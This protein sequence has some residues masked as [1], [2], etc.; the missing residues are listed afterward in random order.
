MSFNIVKN[1][2]TKAEQTA[3]HLGQAA[4]A[5]LKFDG[6]AGNIDIAS[7]PDLGTKFSFELIIQSD[8]FGS[9]SQHFIDFGT[10]GRFILASRSDVDG[11]N[12]AINDN[13]AWT[14]F[15]VKV[16]DDLKVHHLTLTVDGTAAI[17]YNNGNQVATVTISASHGIDNCTNARIG[18]NEDG[19]GQF[20]DGTIYRARF[21]NKT[22]SQ[23]EVTASYENATVPFA[24]Q[25]GVQTELIPS[26]GN[27]TFASGIGNWSA[28]AI[29]PTN[30]G[31]MLKLD[32]ALAYSIA[33]NLDAFGNRSYISDSYFTSLVEGK[34]YRL[35]LDAKAETAGSKLYSTF[36]AGGTTTESITLTDSTA[37]YEF[38]FT[39]GSGLSGTQYLLFGLDAAEAFWIDNLTLTRVGAVAD[40]DL[41]F[42]NPTQSLLVQDRAGAADGTSSATGV[43]QVTPIVQVNATAARIGTSAATP[44]DGEL[45]VSGKVEV[46]GATPILR[47]ND[48]DSNAPFEARVEGTSFII[49]DVNNDRDL[50]TATTGHAITIGN[51][52]GGNITLNTSANTLIPT[53]NVG[54]GG[55]PSV[56]ANKTTLTTNHATWGG[57]Y[58]VA[59]NGTVKSAWD[60]GTSGTTN[61]GSVVAEPLVLLTNSAARVTIDG[62]TGLATFAG[63]ALISTASSPKLDVTSTGA[64]VTNTVQADDASGYLGTSTNHPLSLRTNNA[65]RVTIPATGGIYEVG[66]VLKSNLLT[67]SGFD[68][69]SNSTL[70]DVTGSNLIVS[71]DDPDYPYNTFTP[72]GV[73]IDSAITTD[74]SNNYCKAAAITGVTGKLYKL[75]ATLT[76]NS[77]SNPSINVSA[78]FGGGTS[79]LAATTLNAG[80][81]TLVFE[82]A[83][84]TLIVWINNI[85]NTNWDCDFTLTEVT[86]GCVSGT[87]NFDGWQR[88]GGTDTPCWRQHEDATFTKDGSFY[89]LKTTSVQSAWNHA[90]PS[91]SL[92]TDAKFLSRFAGRTVT[93]GCW[94]YSTLATPEIRLNIYTNS[95]DN[96]STQTVA[97][98]TWTW[99]ETT[100]TCPDALTNFQL[101]LNK[102]GS[103][104]ETYYVSQVCLVFGSAIGE[105]NYTRPSG[106]IVWFEKRVNSNLLPATGWSDVAATALNLEADSNGVIP[107]GANAIQFR[108]LA[109]DSGSA[110]ATNDGILTLG[111]DTSTPE[112]N[113]RTN[114][115]TN[116]AQVFQ[117]GWQSCGSDGD[118]AYTIAATGSAT[119]DVGTFQY[120][121][122]QLR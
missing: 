73:N 79:S 34:K 89:S 100:A 72:N 120:L 29:T 85:G 27:R 69:W 38:V 110:A 53:G 82:A 39:A 83:T 7:P 76:L 24:D 77:G 21:W 68:V 56:V 93:A 20:I 61:F 98:N 8:S 112:Q 33:A 49:N 99:L 67:N 3:Q 84:D 86:P 22:L 23:A 66:G 74:G 41:A 31:G 12:L 71:W 95:G 32:Q 57:R 75:T 115:L 10:G 107:K 118:I 91:Q 81:N 47:L 109:N 106:E 88:R 65:A 46:S 45:A 103:T 111:R 102:S 50:F 13:T 6:A 58:E 78:A 36:Q 26:A 2:Y 64:T 40:Y 52:A 105:G 19:L 48:T 16:L 15:G 25:Y 70:E 96:F 55:T 9:T 62:S 90:W 108:G 44:A 18:A 119:L 97:Q 116:D 14:S 42:A 104:S 30:D 4:E 37:A 35:T 11:Y 54:I 113:I 1:K 94:V 5:G 63:N 122:V 59:L 43:V 117:M 92:I 114:G 101:Q 51:G 28:V 17:L 87:L 80:V 121:G 60:W